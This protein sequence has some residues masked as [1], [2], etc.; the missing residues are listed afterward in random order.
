M[1]GKDGEQILNNHSSSVF[2]T[3]IRR[4]FTYIKMY[5]ECVSGIFSSY[6][7]LVLDSVCQQTFT[8]CAFGIDIKE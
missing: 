3:R 4:P 5:H 2:P 6:R 7:V 8:K 1:H